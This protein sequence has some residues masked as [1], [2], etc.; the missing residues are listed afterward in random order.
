MYKSHI[1]NIKMVNTGLW[2]FPMEFVRAE[3]IGNV[4]SLVEVQY[5][6]NQY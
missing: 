1:I 2:L 3:E 5:I 4:D 6:I